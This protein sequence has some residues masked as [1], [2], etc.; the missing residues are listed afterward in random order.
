MEI[1][2]SHVYSI[3]MCL[4]TISMPATAQLILASSTVRHVFSDPVTK[5]VFRLTLTGRSLMKSQ[6]IF[7]ITN[8]RG[9]SIYYKKFEGA[10]LLDMVENEDISLIQK[11]DYIRKRVRNFFDE[12]NFLKPAIKVKDKT[13]SDYSNMEIWNE[14]RDNRNAIGFSYLLSYENHRKIAWSNKLKKTVIYWNCC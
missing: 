5:D 1:R 12:K 6:A 14:I 9:A 10:L 13:D 2:W 7:E 3:M 4:L 11:E 8:S